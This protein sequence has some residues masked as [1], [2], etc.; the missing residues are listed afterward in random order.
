MSIERSECESD[1]RNGHH[2]SCS[3]YIKRVCICGHLREKHDEEGMDCE[4]CEC[5]NFEEECQ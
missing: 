3:R 1:L 2:P 5:D 4:Q